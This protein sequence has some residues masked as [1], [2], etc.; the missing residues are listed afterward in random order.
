MRVADS[1]LGRIWIAVR[2]AKDVAVRLPDSLRELPALGN[3]L[4]W[5]G[6]IDLYVD[7]GRRSIGDIAD[8]L[9][10]RTSDE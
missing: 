7:M 4:P 8:L 5:R 10:V 3:W 6:D 9:V 1:R 2:P